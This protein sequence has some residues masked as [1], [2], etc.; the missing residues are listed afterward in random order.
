MTKL[1]LKNWVQESIISI[2]LGIEFYLLIMKNNIK[3][4]KIIRT[5]NIFSLKIITKIEEKYKM[6]KQNE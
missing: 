4:E 1:K 2:I 3:K 5:K 6:V